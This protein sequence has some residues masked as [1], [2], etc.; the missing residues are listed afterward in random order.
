VVDLSDQLA[1]PVETLFGVQLGGGTP[2]LFPDLMA[3]SL[4]R[5]DLAA[6]AA[7]RDIALVRAT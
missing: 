1:D 5:A 2:D 6:W 7:A 4:R 3:N